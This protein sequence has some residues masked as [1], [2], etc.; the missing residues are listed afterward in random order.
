MAL[1]GTFFVSDSRMLTNREAALLKGQ[2]WE[3][4]DDGSEVW[5]RLAIKPSPPQVIRH[6]NEEL[7]LIRAVRNLK[8]RRVELLMELERLKGRFEAVSAMPMARLLARKELATLAQQIEA[9]RK[10]LDALPQKPTVHRLDPDASCGVL[11]DATTKVIAQEVNAASPPEVPAAVPPISW[12][13]QPAAAAPAA[14]RTAPRI[15]P[16][17]EPA[18]VSQLDSRKA[19]TIDPDLEALAAQPFDEDMLG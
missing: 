17:A 11:A 5:Q 6:A 14:T 19:P 10:R 15:E 9:Q 4:S 3:S 8:R 2:W 12:P 1:D 16:I 18:P 7:A 13:P